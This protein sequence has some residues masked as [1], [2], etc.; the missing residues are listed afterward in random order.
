MATS[1]ELIESVKRN[2]QAV[3]NNFRF[4]DKDI[5]KIATECIKDIVTPTI[6]SLSSD[7]LL[8]TQYQEVLPGVQTYEVPYRSVGSGVSSMFWQSSL[9]DVP[10]LKR[11]LI[12]H[13]AKDGELIYNPQNYNFYGFFFE[14]DSEYTLLP[15]VTPG[16]SNLGYVKILYFIEHSKLVESLDTTTI[17]SV[18]YNTGQI[19]IEDAP[20]TKFTA[21]TEFDFVKANRKSISKIISIDVEI[22]SQAGTT[23]VFNPADIPEGLV[24]GDKICIAG[25]TDILLTPKEC[26]KYICKHVENVILEAQGDSEKLRIAQEDLISLRRKMETALTPRVQFQAQPVVTN[27]PLLNRSRAFNIRLPGRF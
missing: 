14:G 19:T 13:S 20:N 18:D 26:F 3:G 6:L 5:L 9:E 2:Q 16:G 8:F 1:Q 12:L 11:E 22:Q 10:S 7:R 17:V 23:L 4:S 15:R 21:S 25:Q 27:R 24:A